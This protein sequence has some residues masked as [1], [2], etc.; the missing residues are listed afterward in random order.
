MAKSDNHECLI[1]GRTKRQSVHSYY[2]GSKTSLDG[3]IVFY[4]E[5]VDSRGGNS[6]VSYIYNLDIGLNT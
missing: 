1:G 5:G 2:T 6:Y 3:Q 4:C